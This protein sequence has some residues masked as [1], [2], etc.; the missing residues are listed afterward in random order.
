VTEPA[1]DRVP[2]RRTRGSLALYSLA[3]LLMLIAGGLIV[4]AIRSFLE[5]I[6]PLWISAVLS[7]IAIAAA[8]ASLL[9]PRRP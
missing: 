9:V 1:D 3:F 7:G 6:T 8:V 5:T 4:V 2:V